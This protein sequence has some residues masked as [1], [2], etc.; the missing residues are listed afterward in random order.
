MSNSQEQK[1]HKIYEP[2]DEQKQALGK[3][4]HCALLEIR[5]LGWENKAQQAADLADAFHNLPIFMYSSEF[6]WSFFRY[7]IQTYQ[8]KYPRPEGSHFDYVT[9]LNKIEKLEREKI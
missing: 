8:S 4:L 9:D 1:P 2:N 5:V 6:D 3:M 7:F